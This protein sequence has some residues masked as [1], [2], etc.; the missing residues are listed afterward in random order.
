MR[1]K[2]PANT[3]SHFVRMDSLNVKE[4]IP[5]I[6]MKFVDAIFPRVRRE[7]DAGASA[8]AAPIIANKTVESVIPSDKPSRLD[9]TKA[10]P[11]SI[12]APNRARRGQFLKS[13]DLGSSDQPWPYKNCW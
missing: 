11:L 8:A 7:C 9:L 5:Q 2:S 3:T 12:A 1:K 10:H 13:L 4:S 6:P